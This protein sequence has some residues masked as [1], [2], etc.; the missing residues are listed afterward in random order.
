MMGKHLSSNLSDFTMKVTENLSVC[1]VLL[2][3]YS[4]CLQL[5]SGGLSDVGILIYFR[6]LSCSLSNLI[7]MDF[8]IYDQATTSSSHPKPCPAIASH[9][10]FSIACGGMEPWH[11]SVC[12][13]IGSDS[14]FGTII[15]YIA[16]FGGHLHRRL[17]TNLPARS[18]TT[19]CFYTEDRPQA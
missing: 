15:K 1:H 19:H 7:K 3:S 2:G 5:Q 18:T 4:F 12:P 6:R 17:E 8:S 13:E 9:L 10:C 16:I 11:Y 14:I